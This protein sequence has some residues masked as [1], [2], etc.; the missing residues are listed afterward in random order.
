M[1]GSSMVPSPPC[2]LVRLRDRL[3]CGLRRPGMLGCQPR[4]ESRICLRDLV[5]DAAAD[6]RQHVRFGRRG[7]GDRRW[8]V[9]VE[10]GVGEDLLDSVP[11]MDALE[12]EPFARAIES[13]QPAAGEQLPWPARPVHGWWT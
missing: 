3:A 13:K 11:G 4:G 6:E 12:R 7:R 2:A 9:E 8:P 1:P 10:A 5:A